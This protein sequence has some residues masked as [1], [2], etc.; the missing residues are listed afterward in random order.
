M[1]KKYLLL[2]LLFYGSLFGYFRPAPGDWNIM[3][4]FLYL[5]PTVDDTYFVIKSPITT[6]FPNGTKENND[7]NIWP[8]FRVGGAI[9]FC[10]SYRSINGYYSWLLA[11]KTRR[12]DG[13]FLWA[14]MGPP[15]L[16]A[17]FENYTGEA[18]SSLDLLYQRA[19]IVLTQR[20][21]YNNRGE[22]NFFGGLEFGYG[23]LQEDYLYRSSAANVGTIDQKSRFWGLGP[24]IGCAFD[25]LICQF[26][27]RSPGILTLEA[28]VSAS[29]LS[30]KN[31][32]SA[33]DLLNTTTVV[34]V[35]NAKS[36]RLLPVFHTLVGFNYDM[37]CL[38][39]L[40]PS[41][42]LGLEFDCYSRALTRTIYT[43]DTAESTSLT[44]YY[45][46]GLQGFYASLTL[47]F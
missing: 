32:E 13:Q 25:Y 3:S 36:W 1:V 8:G 19:D 21:W 29:L 34:N 6:S 27:K 37:W 35:T 22:L 17:S 18:S 7:F 24:E 33:F 41:F 16:I 38:P 9:G 45:D 5:L 28:I 20:F 2:S 43:D 15:D 46:L 47:T 40:R 12:V 31:S 23:R 11:K 44:N 14:T 26:T 42:A 4:S 39:C 30:T 10:D